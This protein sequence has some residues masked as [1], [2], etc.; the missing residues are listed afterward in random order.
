VEEL[1][2]ASRVK[3][4]FVSTMSHELRTSLHVILGY[5]EMIEEA[6]APEDPRRDLAQR[7]R[8]SGRDLLELIDSTLD[9]G[10]LEAGRDEPRFEAVSL[11]RLWERLRGEC[12]ELPRLDAVTLDWSVEVPDASLVT[13][14]HKLGIVMRNLVSN[15]LKFTEQGSV[16]AGARLDGD[17]VVLRVADTGIGIGEADRAVIFEMFRQADSS[18]SRR[19][20]GSGLGLYIARRF[21]EQLGGTITLESAPQHGSVFTVTL[22]RARAGSGQIAA[23]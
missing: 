21:V 23:A 9:I 3:S 11:R 18:D 1:A 13:D 10:R 4:D 22:P 2:Q 15:A 5:A 17:R 14:P 8:T 12:A 19:F 7:V 20:G 16:Q 6:T